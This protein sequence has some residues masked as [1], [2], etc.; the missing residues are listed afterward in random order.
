VA[1]VRCAVRESLEEL[2][3]EREPGLVLVAC[4]GGADSVALASATAFEAP[5]LGF[6]IGGVSID[7][8]LQEG[9]ARRAAE[10]VALLSSLGFDPVEAVA[11]DVL[12]GKAGQGGPEAAARTA[13]YAALDAVAD[14][15][16]AVTVLLG[17]T[18]NDQA[19][20][21][22]LGL[23]RG[24]GTRSLAGMAS[25]QAAGR[26]RRPLLEVTRA[27]TRATCADLGLAVWDDPQNADPTF[28]RV[29]VRTE[30]LPVMEAALGPGIAEALA[31][32][33]VLA[34][35]DADALDSWAARSHA[36]LAGPDGS[37][38]AAALAELP[39]AVRRR[40]LRLAALAAGASGVEAVHLHAA[41]ALV[42]DWHGQGAVSLPG[43]RVAARRYGRLYL[44]TQIDTG[45]VV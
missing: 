4:S 19:E 2:L 22:L 21:V 18:L 9:S 26:Y 31:R 29:R 11:V 33:A 39:P 16:G 20:T 3:K 8:G 25:T 30:V 24:S 34:R 32:T 6:R 42:T 5:R 23:A 41:D 1:A 27:M 37:L 15:L 35:D 43:G 28:A 44:G 10:V 38:E 17:H 40:V 12:A 7:H 14:R 36:E 45:N 13:R